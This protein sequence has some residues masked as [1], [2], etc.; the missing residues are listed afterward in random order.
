[1]IN[2]SCD[3]NDNN[4]DPSF[5]NCG[6]LIDSRDGQE[7]KT[8]I[9]GDKCWMAENLN[10]GVMIDGEFNQSDNDTI[11][12]YC[13][14][15]D[16]ANCNIYGGL[17]Q[18]DEMMLYLNEPGTQGIC[19]NGWYL[20]SDEDWKQLEIEL[21][22]SEAAANQANKWR[23]HGVGTALKKGGYT[24][25]NALFAGAR[26]SSGV[27]INI[28]ESENPFTYFHTSSEAEIDFFSWRRC[29]SPEYSSV[30]RFDSF[31]KKYGLSVRCV[32]DI[33]D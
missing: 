6:V 17:Y 13:Y 29:L 20:P 18:W 23:G 1:M 24:G 27:F 9:I 15:N 22:M 14:D 12:K 32:K 7:Y 3:K 30:G 11:E 8:V 26:T 19:P 2:V 31:S 10:I 4:E 28:D 21:G 25:F 33:K 5:D 16:P